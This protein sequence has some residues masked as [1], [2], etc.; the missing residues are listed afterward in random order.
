MDKKRES[1]TDSELNCGPGGS[2]A[3]PPAIP[4]TDSPEA[5]PITRKEDGTFA[6]GQSGNL[7]GRTKGAKGKITLYKAELEESFRRYIGG[8]T[9]RRTD[10]FKTWDRMIEIALTGDEKNAVAAYKAFSQQVLSNLRPEEPV[11]GASPGKIV[12]EIHN[13]TGGD[14]PAVGVVIDDVEFEEVNNG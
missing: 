14:E 1:A 2:V 3:H 10:L 4:P 13:H 5:A 8:S 7:K 12:V 11:D 6:P 9:Q